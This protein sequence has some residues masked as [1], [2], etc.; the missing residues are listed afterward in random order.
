MKCP[1]HYSNVFEKGDARLVQGSMDDD[2]E[3][4]AGV[5]NESDGRPGFQA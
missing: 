1:T 5:H 3:D 2:L 4:T